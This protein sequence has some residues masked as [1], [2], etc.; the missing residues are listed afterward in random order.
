M[1]KN[2]YLIKTEEQFKV[3][4]RGNL[5]FPDLGLD[6]SSL[7]KKRRSFSRVCLGWSERQH[8]LAG[9]LGS[10]LASYFFDNQWITHIRSTR[11]VK[12]TNKGKSGLKRYFDYQL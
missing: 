7:R 2:G 5:F 10:A 9:T 6:L 12:I 8:H 11:A 4:E 1:V 3:T